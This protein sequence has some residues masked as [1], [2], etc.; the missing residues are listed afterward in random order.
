MR[1]HRACMRVM[2]D[3]IDQHGLSE[4]LDHAMV[5]QTGN[6]NFWL[7][8]DSFLDE[9]SDAEDPEQTLLAANASLRSE[10]ADQSAMVQAVQGALECHQLQRD[11][12]HARMALEDMRSR[13]LRTESQ[14]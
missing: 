8:N 5:E 6:T 4:E 7:G 3:L 10:A 13:Q 2:E 1:D 9:P 12:E 11:L 14:Q